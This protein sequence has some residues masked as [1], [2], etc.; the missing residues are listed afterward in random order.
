M[1][2]TKNLCLE[3]TKNLQNT[4]VKKHSPIRIWTKDIKRHFTEEDVQ[5]AN[6]NMK[7]CSTLLAIRENAN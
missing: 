3:Y 5:M 2:L 7:R 4:T 6:K 1:Y